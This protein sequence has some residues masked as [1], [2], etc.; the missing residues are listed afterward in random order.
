MKKT[1][2]AVVSAILVI[3]G[4]STSCQSGTKSADGT[5]AGSDSTVVEEKDPVKMAICQYLTDSIG[6]QYSQGDVCIPVVSILDTEGSDGDTLRVW[7]DFWVFNYQ[8]S[9]DTLKTVSGG[10]HAGMLCLSHD[11]DN[12]YSVVDFD[13]VLDGSENEPSA[14]RI[15]AERYDTY[16]E[17]TSDQ[18]KRDSV[19]LEATSEYVCNH[20]LPV[21]LMQDYGWPPVSLLE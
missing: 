18:S 10:S 8:L 9:G 16:H 13:P 6:S 20:K 14:R 5:D 21:K 19:R 11:A 2:L 4:V 15:F 12:T 7:G 3:C 1:L 17:L